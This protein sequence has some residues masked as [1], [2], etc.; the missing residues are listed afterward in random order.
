MT[1]TTTMVETRPKE[2]ARERV[3]RG[4]ALLDEH[5]PGWH[6]K[7]DPEILAIRSPK[8]CICGQVFGSFQEGVRVLK[9]SGE[10][11]RYGFNAAP[12]AGVKISEVEA[13]WRDVLEGRAA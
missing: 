13:Q 3:L 2:S 10:G 8:N 4:V 11:S 7:V 9:L 5:A 1:T 6:E 12:S